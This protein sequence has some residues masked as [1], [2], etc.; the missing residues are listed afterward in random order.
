MTN[1]TGEIRKFLSHRYIG[2]K[3]IDT[4]VELLQYFH[5]KYT[6]GDQ[7]ALMKALI[8]CSLYQEHIPDWVADELLVLDGKL[9]SD[10]SS[11]MNTFLGLN[12]KLLN[13]ELLINLRVFVKMRKRLLMHCLNIVSVGVNFKM[14]MA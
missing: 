5:M 13:N 1:Y 3:A 4:M 7:T 2:N 8:V 14:K 11:D 10:L 9:A 6:D 12:V